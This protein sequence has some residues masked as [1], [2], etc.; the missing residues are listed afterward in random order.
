MAKTLYPKGAEKMLRGAINFEADTIKAAMLSTAYT[1]SIA[2]EFFSDVVAHIVGTAQ[3]LTGQTA[4]GGI[5]DANDA[6]FGA[7]AAGSTIGAFVIFKSTGVDS[8]SPLLIYSTE[9]TGFPAATNGGTITIPWNNGAG[10]I[11]SLV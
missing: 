7:V 2:H 11:M 9:A 3:T 8:T 6:E 4:A 1:Y 10:R 5:F